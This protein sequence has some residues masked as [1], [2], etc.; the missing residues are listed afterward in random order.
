MFTAHLAGSR[1]QEVLERAEDLFNPV[2]P[3]PPPQQPRRWDRG[4]T[5]QEVTPFLTGLVDED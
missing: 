5:T 3:P 2:T 1:G 4:G